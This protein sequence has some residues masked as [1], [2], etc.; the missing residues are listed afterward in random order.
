MESGGQRIWNGNGGGSDTM[1]LGCNAV[2]D[3]G[4]MERGGDILDQLGERE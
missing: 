3:G 2:V 1:M 4:E